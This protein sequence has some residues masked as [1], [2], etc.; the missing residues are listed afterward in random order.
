[1][2]VSLGVSV[3]VAE[4][5]RVG[6][7]VGVSLGVCVGVGE[8]LRVG[9]GVKVKLGAIDGIGDVVGAWLGLGV[10]EAVLVAADVGLPVTDAVGM[11]VESAGAN[12]SAMPPRQ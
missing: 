4:D 10:I 12:A 11:G 5:V 1:V 7:A 6:D 8:G 9:D 2:G 3:G